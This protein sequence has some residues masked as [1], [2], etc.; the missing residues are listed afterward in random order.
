MGQHFTFT[1]NTLGLDR[2]GVYTEGVFHHAGFPLLSCIVSALIDTA[3]ALSR[4]LLQGLP[5]FTH[6]DVFTYTDLFRGTGL[7]LVWPT[8]FEGGNYTL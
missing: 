2:G 1:L 7:H 5:V 4:S 8:S 3:L 6:T